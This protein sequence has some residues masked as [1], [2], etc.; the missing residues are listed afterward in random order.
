M[1]FLC[2]SMGSTY[3]KYCNFSKLAKTSMSLNVHTW[4]INMKNM[5]TKSL[6]QKDPLI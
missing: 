2:F 1:F 4:E 5:H 6:A 3:D